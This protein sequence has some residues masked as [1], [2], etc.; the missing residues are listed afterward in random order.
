MNALCYR[1]QEHLSSVE[2]GLFAISVRKRWFPW[3][4]SFIVG[5][6]DVEFS[7]GRLV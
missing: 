1:L 6:I 5:V 2:S 7:G 3:F 4:Q